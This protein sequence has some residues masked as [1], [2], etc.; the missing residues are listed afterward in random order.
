MSKSESESEK[1]SESEVESDKEVDIES[2][3]DS[4]EENEPEEEDMGGGIE[5]DEPEVEKVKVH[6][7]KKK[8][9]VVPKKYKDNSH[10]ITR[11]TFPY[12]KMSIEELRELGKLLLKDESVVYEKY[13]D[14]SDFKE[15]Y[16]NI[17]YQNADSKEINDEF[18]N[19]QFKKERDLANMII[20]QRENPPKMVKSSEKCPKCKGNTT[21]YIPL[22]TRSG[23]E[24]MTLFFNCES[25]DKIG[26]IC[27]NRWA[28]SG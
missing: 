20:N 22:Q 17:L 18:N 10:C 11:E 21:F 13:K 8:K 3:R 12:K 6:K 24:P 9:D 7:K 2:D 19:D 4:E 28:K 14:L 23:D 27:G 26:N 16:I 1:E 25:I 15:Q 5:W